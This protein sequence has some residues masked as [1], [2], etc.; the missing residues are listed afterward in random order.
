M[1]KRMKKMAAWLLGFVMLLHFGAAAAESGL[2]EI[3][4][5][6]GKLNIRPIA[7]EEEAIAYA[8]EIW[9]L[10]YIG[11][12]FGISFWEANRFEENLW[13]VYAMDGEDEGDYCYGDVMF[14][15]DGN[16][17]LFENASSGFF[18]VVNEAESYETDENAEV[19]IP[20][21]EDERAAWHDEMDRKTEYPFLAAVCPSVWEEYTALYPAGEAGNEFLTYYYGTYTDSYDSQIMFDLDYSECYRD[22]TWRIKYGVQTSPVVRIVYFDVYTDAEEG[23]NG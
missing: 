11:M 10:D 6:S 3:P 12:D 7:T 14:D 15:M 4:E 2:P 5:F 9:A 19:V 8:K 23:G 16:V 17:V 13:V 20:E 22:G 1:M 21:N 18:E